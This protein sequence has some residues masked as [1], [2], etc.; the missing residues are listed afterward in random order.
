MV[1]SEKISRL[2]ESEESIELKLY[3]E[4]VREEL[5]RK[6][7]PIRDEMLEEGRLPYC[8]EWLTPDEI[9]LER[10]QEKKDKLTRLVLI[11]LIYLLM[12][13]ISLGLC[14]YVWRSAR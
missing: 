1:W 5:R 7:E 8:G 14:L 3:R 12:F 6:L 4:Q 10:E 11:L 13:A 2:I 9:M